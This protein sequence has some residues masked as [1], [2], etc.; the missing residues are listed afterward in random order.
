LSRSPGAK[1]RGE[2][3]DGFTLFEAL[4]ALTV[5]AISLG[6]L[7]NLTHGTTRSVNF[8]ERRLELVETARKALA[9]LPDREA[10]VEGVSEGELNGER[11]RI[12]VGP[13]SDAAAGGWEPE[14]VRLEV[15]SAGG[16]RVEIDTLRLRRRS[17][18]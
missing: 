3:R 15:R 11:W 17:G 4:A 8:A 1:S 10:L 7:A 6:A 12:S 16:D 14:L 5:V 2:G 9:A 13:F 18:R